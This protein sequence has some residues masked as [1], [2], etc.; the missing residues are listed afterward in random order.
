MSQ[1]KGWAV[2]PLDSL[3]QFYQYFCSIF[4][5]KIRSKS[6]FTGGRIHFFSRHISQG[7]LVL[8]F[9]ITF[10][11]VWCSDPVGFVLSLSLSFLPCHYIACCLHIPEC[12]LVIEELWFMEKQLGLV[13]NNITL[14]MLRDTIISS[15]STPVHTPSIHL[16]HSQCSLNEI[17]LWSGPD[18]LRSEAICSLEKLFRSSVVRFHPWLAAQLLAFI[19]VLIPLLKESGDSW[20][21]NH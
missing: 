7:W 8:W 17:F 1:T 2:M 16:F 10:L 20:F 5:I 9:C 11:L 18:L 19:A 21:R 6:L 13:V 4:F 3:L 14:N 12:A 15:S